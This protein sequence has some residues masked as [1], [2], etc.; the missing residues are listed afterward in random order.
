MASRTRACA[1]SLA[2]TIGSRTVLAHLPI[3]DIAYLIGA[4]LVSAIIYIMSG[5]RQSAGLASTPFR[6]TVL[7]AA[8]VVALYAPV[9][10]Y[11]FVAFDDDIV[12][13]ANPGLRGGLSFTSI[14]W[15]LRTTYFGNWMPLT[16]FSHLLDVEFFGM[17]PRGHHLQSVLLHA[18]VS[19]LCFIVLRRAT[20][21]FRRSLVVAL[22]FAVHPLHVEAVAWVSAR[23]DLLSAVFWMLG[24]L[25]YLRYVA[26]PGAGR[27]WAVAATQALGLASKAS[28][29]TFP[30]ALLVLD[31]WPLGR[32]C[33][34]TAPHRPGV[35]PASRLVMEKLPLLALSA[36]FARGAFISQSRIGAIMPFSAYPLPTRLANALA[37]CVGYL[38]DLAFPFGLSAYYIHPGS[39]MG[40]LSV[41]G[42]GLLLAALSVCCFLVVRRHPYLAAGWLWF[43]VTLLPVIG[44][45]QLG[46]HARA[47]RYVYIPL[48]GPL[49]GVVW[50]AG[51]QWNQRRFSRWVLAVAAAATILLFAAASRRQLETWSDSR[52]L[53]VHALQVDPGSWH[54]ENNYGLVLY[55][56]GRYEE[57]IGHFRRALEQR[58]TYVHAWNNLGAALQQLG[59]LDEAIAHY[60]RGLRA[61]PN[62]ATALYNFGL[63]LAAK[64]LPGAAAE[65]YR[66]A[67]KVDPDYRDAKAALDRL[68]P[69]DR[70]FRP[71]SGSNR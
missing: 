37:S 59:R 70:R 16:W 40:L 38:G 69:E 10:G 56:E 41:A 5:N 23:R 45:V 32:G 18:L 48:L 47:D 22:I 17:D 29:V 15:A 9:T 66:A 2:G 42:A 27:Y 67:L 13:T 33:P 36:A 19:A 65:K 31:W 25:A 53:F 20:G 21:A 14:S 46:N 64:G 1:F 58:P 51:E 11:E 6:A 71:P 12:I 30:L 35:L 61:G 57:A 43:L 26:A 34:R 28:L 50:V 7:V 44:L 54:A 49:L 68:G 52:A 63:A 62:T 55:R 24:L 3:S 4:G 39:G 8:V 60:E